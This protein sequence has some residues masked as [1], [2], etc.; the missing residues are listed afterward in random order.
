MRL[1]LFQTLSRD[2]TSCA[3]ACQSSALPD[4]CCRPCPAAQNA[5]SFEMTPYL[6]GAKGPA[7]CIHFTSQP[8]KV[9][10]VPRAGGPPQVR[11]G[12]TAAAWKTHQWVC[13][14]MQAVSTWH[15]ARGVARGMLPAPVCI[16][17]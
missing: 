2:A 11:G 12:L 15:P 7:Q 9:H 1:Q 5:M 8:M 17:Q 10:L 3:C 13:V 6:L 4:P 16:Q 14:P